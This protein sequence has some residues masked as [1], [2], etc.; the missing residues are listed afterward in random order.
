MKIFFSAAIISWLIIQVLIVGLLFPADFVFAE[1][2]NLCSVDADV[3]MVLDVSDSMSEGESPSLCEW[4][5]REWNDDHTSQLCAPYSEEGLTEQDCLAKPVCSVNSPVYTPGVPSKIESA[6]TA[7]KSFLD[8]LEEQDQSALVIFSDT[9]QL[10]KN[11]SS[12]H[13]STKSAIDGITTEGYTNIGDAISE[14]IAELSSGNA[15]PQ[16]TKTIILLTDGKANR[17]NG[18]GDGEDATDVAYAEQKAQEAAG[19]GYKI[20]TIGLGDDVNSGM[21]L[22]IANIT[23]ANYHFASNGNGLSDIYVLISQEICQYSSISGC[24]Y[25]DLNNNGEIDNGE[26]ALPD[27][28]II[29]SGDASSS[30]LTDENGCYT[31]A[32]LEPGNYT[33][34]ESE[35]I[36]KTPFLQTYP[37]D[38]FYNISLS[39]GEDLIEKDFANYFPVCGNTIVDE[40]EQCDDGNTANGDGCSA[41]CQTEQTG[42][43]QPEDFDNQQGCE[44]AGFYWYDNTCHG[45]PQPG[46]LVAPE[47]GYVVINEIMQNPLAVSDTNGEWFEL[48][49]TTDYDIDMTGCVIRDKA[50]NLHTITSFIISAHTY[51][52]LAKNGDTNQNGGLTANYV[53]SNTTFN[54]TSDSIILDCDSVEIDRVDYDGGPEF[55]KPDGAS[56]IL[57]NPALNNNVGANWCV[58]TTPY[59]LGDL[60]T[61]GSLNDSCGFAPVCGNTIIEQGEQCDDGNTS[62]GD[63]CSAVCQTETPPGPGDFDNEQDC[64]TAGF[65]WYDNTCHGTPQPQEPQPEDF[66]NQQGCETAGFYWYDNTCHGTPQPQ[67]QEPVCGNTI[68]ES[69]EQC[70]DG[71]TANGDGCSAVCQTETPS[72]GGGGVGGNSYYSTIL[73]SPGEGGS[74]TPLGEVN[75]SYLSNQFF[76]IEP[77][78]AYKVKD[79]LVDGISVGPVDSYFFEHVTG[80]HTISATFSVAKIGDINRDG[81]VD[82]KDLALMLSVWGQT[83]SSVPADLNDDGKIDEYD[84]AILMLH[85]GE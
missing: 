31:F 2:G 51:S 65:Y 35:N 20:F 33:V 39:Q 69:G 70:D 82:D 7:G 16:A 85:W 60:G 9:A 75:V 27:W 84:M 42:E 1:N 46:E 54:N 50:L 36:G 15:N 62:D 66:N 3:V 14:A 78:K 44:G 25:N 22:S 61:P 4:Y 59:G 80:N 41:V 11:L 40:S 30:Q 29:L 52:V 43:P 12:D 72:G 19:L 23:G 79:V 6:K 5:E 63:G 18:S 74:M 10:I 53:Y 21:L 28:E 17:P 45:T 57:G 8:N 68:V 56:M 77:S 64:T 83:D 55:P 58:S 48:Y 34:S 71:N 73:A 26:E 76:S 24:K 32:G 38:S 37:F 13:S 47:P 49:N 67:Q 81:S